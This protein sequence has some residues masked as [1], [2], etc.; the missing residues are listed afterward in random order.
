MLRNNR[1]SLS[2]IVNDSPLFR[3]LGLGVINIQSDPITCYQRTRTRNQPGDKWI[4]LKD[5][6]NLHELH[7]Q[8]I[9]KEN[10][11]VIILHKDKSLQDKINKLSKM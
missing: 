10:E 2:C 5:L 9:G 8:W 6:K 3:L 7:E 4:T 1:P 11:E